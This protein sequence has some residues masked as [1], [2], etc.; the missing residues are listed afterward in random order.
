MGMDTRPR[1]AAEPCR[2]RSNGSGGCLLQP[3]G[4][5]RIAGNRVD[6][7][8]S[9]THFYRVVGQCLLQRWL[10]TQ[11]AQ[12]ELRGAVCNQIG[13]SQTDSLA[14]RPRIGSGR[15]REQVHRPLASPLRERRMSGCVAFE[16][17]PHP[18]LFLPIKRCGDETH[19]RFPDRVAAVRLVRGRNRIFSEMSA[20]AVQQPHD[21]RHACCRDSPEFGEFRMIGDNAVAD[22]LVMAGSPRPSGGGRDELARQCPSRKNADQ[23]QEF[24]SLL[25]NREAISAIPA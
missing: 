25:G 3:G 1:Q 5:S 4:A 17:G 22:Q 15:D 13:A 20:D 10:M 21:L 8:Q 19:S 2:R 23:F 9:L 6:Q 12:R 16:R 11:Q 24:L 18:Q 14:A 7:F